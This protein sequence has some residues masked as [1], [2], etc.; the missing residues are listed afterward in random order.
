MTPTTCYGDNLL[1]LQST[2]LPDSTLKK[3]HASISHH[4]CREQVVAD[5]ILPIKVGI[6]NIILPIC[7]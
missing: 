4:M 2:G 6:G 1:M 3:M 5:V 7:P